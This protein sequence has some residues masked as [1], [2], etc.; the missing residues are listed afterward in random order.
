M[1]RPLSTPRPTRSTGFAT[2]LIGWTAVMGALL[3]PAVPTLTGG[4]LLY[5]VI[6]FAVLGV[7]ALIAV[8]EP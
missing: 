6:G 3:D 1:K 2:M 5:L 8:V 4:R 7:G